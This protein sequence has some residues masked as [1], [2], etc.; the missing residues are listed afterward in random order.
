[1]RN[2]LFVIET[3]IIDVFRDNWGRKWCHLVAIDAIYFRDRSTQYHIKCIKRELTKAYTGF[4]NRGQTRDC[5]FPIA[6]GNWGCGAFNGDRQ[7]KGMKLIRF[8]I[9]FPLL[10]LAIIQLIAASETVRPLIYAAYGDKTLVESF[11]M[12]YDYLI[13]QRATV[14]DLYR[15]LQQYSNGHSRSAFFDFILKTPVTSLGS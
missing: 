8:L 14:R 12:V 10:C 6:T 9:H 4:Y 15:Y 3:E 1:M 2:G 5:S 7:L 11:S 13:A